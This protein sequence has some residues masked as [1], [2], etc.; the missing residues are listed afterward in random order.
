MQAPRE[1]P[2][3][4]CAQAQ[5]RDPKTMMRKIFGGTMALSLVG[6]AV[7]GT[8][9]AMSWGVSG[10]QHGDNTVGAV[11][12]NTFYEQLKDLNGNP[13]LIGPNDGIW[14]TVGHIE[15]ENL[16]SSTFALQLTNGSVNIT[17]TDE[18]K[19]PDNGKCLLQ[20]FAGQV[21][22]T[23]PGPIQPGATDPG[24]GQVQLQVLPS[25]APDCMGH[26]IGY[27]VTLNANLVA[28]S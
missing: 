2:H 26:T 16:S 10:T 14:R 25:A 27:D 4:M 9:F 17:T 3:I 15:M 5:E 7:L 19:A 12:T 21:I 6:A 13:L 22:I 11:Q 24:I 8:V 23:Q 28:T 20:D 1:Q 18:E